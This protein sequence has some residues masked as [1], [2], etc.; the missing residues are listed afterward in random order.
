MNILHINSEKTFRGGEQQMLYL[1]DG[2][3]KRGVDNFAILNQEA[4]VKEELL[5]ILS[6]NK[7]YEI[8]M[9][10]EYDFKAVLKIRKIIFENDI[11]IVHCHTSHAHTLGY[12]A[13]FGHFAKVVV[14]RRV[15][16]SIY[17]KGI[18]FLSKFKYNHMCDKIIAVSSKIREVLIK[19]GIKS[20]K[21][22]V[23]MD[24]IDTEKFKDVEYAYLYNEFNIPENCK[25][26]V[27]VAAL[28]PH[29][30]QEFLIRA[31]KNVLKKHPETL[32]FI[33]GEGKLKDNLIKLT[34]EL[35]ISENIIFTGFRKDVGAFLNIADIFIITSVEEG[36][37]TSI[38]DAL[39]LDKI[40]VATDAGGIPE[41]IRDEETGI[42][43]KKG[44]IDSISRGIIKV[45]DNLEK[46]K[47]KFSKIS[48]YVNTAFSY[49]KM[50]IEHLGL[51]IDLLQY[52]HD[53]YYLKENSTLNK[54]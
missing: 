46:Y 13:A 40:V 23:I 31:M 34:K 48:N 32:L 36:L 20:N 16:F 51:Y 39:A 9:K 6:E 21:I 14:S 10:G 3:R 25:I 33:V 2:L 4:V 24:G 5:N 42:L 41:V 12:L 53:G 52:S 22:N 29:K 44:D 37:C 1:I 17:R 26:L 45:I 30:G 28:V 47:E 11:D 18:R 35:N 38:L 8:P 7:I 49:Y 19:D 15:D 27:N 50:V 54:I 43:V